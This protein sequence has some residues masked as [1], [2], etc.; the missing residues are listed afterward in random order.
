MPRQI[1]HTDVAN[2]TISKSDMANTM[3]NASSG[4]TPGRNRAST[5]YRYRNPTKRRLYQRDLMR[6]RRASGRAA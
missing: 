5:T 6:Q 4:N 2:S 3:A 1:T